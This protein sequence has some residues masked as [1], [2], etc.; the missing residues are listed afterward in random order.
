MICSTDRLM[1][2]KEKMSKYSKESPVY[3]KCFANTLNVAPLLQH[4]N[5]HTLG[6]GVFL[7][8]FN[9]IFCFSKKAELG[10]KLL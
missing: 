4:K 9:Y 1:R 3:M 8:C 6:C 10:Y 5:Y 2:I 7:W